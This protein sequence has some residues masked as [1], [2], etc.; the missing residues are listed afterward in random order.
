MNSNKIENLITKKTPATTRVDEWI[1]AEAGVGASIASGNQ[2]CAKNWAAFIPPDNTSD[3]EKAVKK[4]HPDDPI[5]KKWNA[6]KGI[7]KKI[8]DKSV[9]LKTTNVKRKEININISL[10]RENTNVFCAALM[11]YIRVE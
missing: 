2:T 7:C 8:I 3:I 1:R 11:V 6:I 5:N 4:C 9:E 10:I